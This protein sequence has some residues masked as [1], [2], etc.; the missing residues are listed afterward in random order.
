MECRRS[1][2]EACLK[3]KTQNASVCAPFCEGTLL[4]VAPKGKG[5]PLF[6]LGGGFWKILHRCL[7]CVFPS[8][9]KTAAT[10]PAEVPRISMPGPTGPGLMDT[11]SKL[12]GSAGMVLDRCAALEP[13]PGCAAA[14]S[15]PLR[16]EPRK[17]RLRRRLLQGSSEA[18]LLM[19]RT[20]KLEHPQERRGGSPDFKD[21]QE[22]GAGRLP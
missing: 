2:A 14:A 7:N 8:P 3:G 17:G 16:I 20:Y 5:K 15:Q 18:A 11:E 12:G 9:S 6:F 22:Y 4:V 1:T 10:P 13:T 19:S 21:L